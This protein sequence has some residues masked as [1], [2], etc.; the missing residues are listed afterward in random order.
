L[1]QAAVDVGELAGVNDDHCIG[2]AVLA[3]VAFTIGG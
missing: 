3:P 2:F 1:G